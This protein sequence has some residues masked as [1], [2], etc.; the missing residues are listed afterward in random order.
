MKTRLRPSI[1]HIFVC[2]FI[3]IFMV[4]TPFPFIVSTRHGA[5]APHTSKSTD[6]RSTFCEKLADSAGELIRVSHDRRVTGVME[7][8]HACLR[9]DSTGL[10]ANGWAVGFILIGFHDENLARPG[11]Q[12]PTFEM[13]MRGE[14]V[15]FFCYADE[16]GLA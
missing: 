6:E 13:I 2:F 10:G 1:H 4:Q 9:I 14:V 5:G 16:V 15:D 7:G 3:D 11:G 8:M 12:V